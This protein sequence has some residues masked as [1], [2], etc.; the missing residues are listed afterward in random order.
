[1]NLRN[2]KRINVWTQQDLYAREQEL[3][4]LPE[5][6]QQCVNN[7]QQCKTQMEDFNNEMGRVDQELL[8][9]DQTIAALEARI[10]LMDAL[11]IE[12]KLQLEIKI[13]QAELDKLTP[14]WQVL[15]DHIIPIDREIAPLSAYIN[16]RK[17][18]LKKYE[19]EYETSCNQLKDLKSK[20]NEV[21][22]HLLSLNMEIS[23]L[24]T[25]I[26]RLEDRGRADE[27]DHHHH[28]D[29]SSNTT[30]VSHQ[31]RNGS[32]HVHHQDNGNT[33]HAVG[34]LF[35]AISDGVDSLL[36]SNKRSDLHQKET[37]RVHLINRQSKL[38]QDILDY[39]RERESAISNRGR[40]EAAIQ[41]FE[42]QAKVNELA[43]L[44]NQKSPLEKQAMLLKETIDKNRNELN[45]AQ[46]MLEITKNSLCKL[47]LIAIPY[48]NNN[49][50]ENLVFQ[51][52]DF[53]Q[54]RIPLVMQK[55]PLQ[56][57]INEQQQRVE[58]EENA[59][60]LL[61]LRQQ[62]LESDSFL[63]KALYH[64]NDLFD[65]LAKKTIHD[66]QQYDDFYPAGQ[67]EKV[68]ICLRELKIK[69]QTIQHPSYA[70]SSQESKLD[71]QH[72]LQLCG[73]LWEMLDYLKKDKWQKFVHYIVVILEDINLDEEECREAYRKLNLSFI[74]SS[75]LHDIEE[76][77]QKTAYE[78][79]EKKLQPL[80]ASGNFKKVCDSGLELLKHA[81]NHPDIKFSTVVLQKAAKLREDPMNEKLRQ[82]FSSLAEHDQYGRSHLGKKMG[83]AILAF[84]GAVVLAS[85]VLAE[86]FSFGFASGITLP[87]MVGGVVLSVVGIGIF[88]NGRQKGL[89]KA[90]AKYSQAKESELETSGQRY[91]PVSL[92][93]T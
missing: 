13:Y 77:E 24:T 70:P 40:C 22:S 38:R 64:S 33:A 75:E 79:F 31:N 18:E 15:Q 89:A 17:W 72:Y 87:V 93:S 81:D 27:H 52:G 9:I 3:H 28:H 20:L 59:K 71:Q 76:A 7:I 8:P 73:L 67:S 50:R 25:D 88:A 34:D 5:Q 69:L 66:F 14:E 53:R 6:I 19:R 49:D 54:R 85:A 29:H 57:Q 90:I 42:Y 47:N 32:Y 80:Y 63:M 1:M 48:M 46:S 82:E 36:L 56:I 58:F 26:V 83:G 62:E 78:V 2:Q 65:E 12:K 44:Q 21:D 55:D 23:Q 30:Y 43:K 60:K 39:Q 45:Q 61:M 68:R 37:K 92:V 16:E 84:L 51:L 10:E 91:Q 35:H 11:V 4:D 74:T 41:S 86:Y